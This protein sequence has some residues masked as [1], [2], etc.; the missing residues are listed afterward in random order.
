MVGSAELEPGQ[1][2]WYTP[3]IDAVGAQPEM[4]EGDLAAQIIDGYDESFARRRNP[5]VTLSAID[6]T[7]YP[8]FPESFQDLV[9][10]LT[11]SMAERR[12]WLPVARAQ[13]K[14]LNYAT[15]H[16]DEIDL[17]SFLENLLHPVDGL[18]DEDLRNPTTRTLLRYRTA[19]LM[20]YAGSARGGDGPFHRLP[21]DDRGSKP[22]NN[23]DWVHHGCRLSIVTSSAGMKTTTPSTSIVSTFFKRVSLIN[24]ALR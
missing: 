17:G 22:M 12:G 8:A 4:D 10:D 2:W 7:Q 21:G 24:S 5:T 13:A 18:D 1:G 9:G 19:I 11:G 16:N 20:N 6:L 14:S 3:F 15:D 23:F